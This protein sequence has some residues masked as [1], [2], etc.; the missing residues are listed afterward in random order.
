MMS[1]FGNVDEGI[2]L[3]STSL[4]RELRKIAEQDEGN[5][6][7]LPSMFVGDEHEYLAISRDQTPSESYLQDA[8]E[9]ELP[10]HF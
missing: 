2:A 7:R 9:V 6:D 3:S 4:D 10:Y 5:L 1:F 8:S